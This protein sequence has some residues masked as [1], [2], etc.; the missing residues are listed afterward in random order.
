MK[1]CAIDRFEEAVGYGECFNIRVDGTSMLPLLGYGRDTIIIRRIRNDEPIDGRI[2]MYRLEAKH[3]VTHRVVKVDGETVTTMGDGR[4]TR[5]EPIH[6]S[7]IIG[8]VEGVIRKS[9]LKLSCTSRIWRFREWLWLWQPLFIRR[10]A[11][12]IIHRW[13][14]LTKKQ[15]K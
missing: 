2:V 8:V 13:M 4:I 6:R 12:A 15:T 3:Y 1:N 10:Y 7:M 5:D 14:R 11:L 9:G